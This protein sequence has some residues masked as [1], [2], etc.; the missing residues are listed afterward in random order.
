MPTML[1]SYILSFNAC[2]GAFYL[3]KSLFHQTPKNCWIT[4][5]WIQQL[6]GVWWNKLLVRCDAP[7]YLFSKMKII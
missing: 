2:P 3:S 6:L 7:G 1:G 5:Q 4:K